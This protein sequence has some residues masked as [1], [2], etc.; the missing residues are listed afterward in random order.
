MSEELAA[1]SE[2]S[3]AVQ[4][5]PYGTHERGEAH[6]AEMI[7]DDELQVLVHGKES[8]AV[9]VGQRIGHHHRSFRI[10]EGV[11]VERLI[12]ALL[13][14]LTGHEEHRCVDEHLGTVV[15]PLQEGGATESLA[16]I[17]G[18]GHAALRH[19]RLEAQLLFHVLVGHGEHQ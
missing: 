7:I 10:G 3:A 9:E 14:F 4:I 15:R 12:V 18:H 11:C 16:K 1:F 5:A 2:C 13:I 6:V 17:G 8:H 19:V